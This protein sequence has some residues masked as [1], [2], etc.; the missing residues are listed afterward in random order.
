MPETFD[1]N[2]WNEQAYANVSWSTAAPSP[3]QIRARP[4]ILLLKR[5]DKIPHPSAQDT[6]RA[7]NG[8]WSLQSSR[9]NCIDEIGLCDAGSV[10]GGRK[11]GCGGGHDDGQ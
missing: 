2:A 4:R 7:V 3:P 5:T 9:L 1:G 11:F 6:G 8:G 10:V